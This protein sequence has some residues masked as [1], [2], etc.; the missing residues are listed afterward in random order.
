LLKCCD[1]S[2]ADREDRKN[3]RSAWL[4][5]IRLIREYNSKDQVPDKLNRA[6]SLPRVN[7]DPPRKHER[8]PPIADLVGP[9][10]QPTGRCGP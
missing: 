4:A 5:N 2:C 8:D 6:N 7:N 3:A 9:L 1:E 10:A